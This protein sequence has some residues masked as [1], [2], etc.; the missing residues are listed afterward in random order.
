MV[1]CKSMHDLCSAVADLGGHREHVHE[2]PLIFDT[3]FST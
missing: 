2:P 1:C 3:E